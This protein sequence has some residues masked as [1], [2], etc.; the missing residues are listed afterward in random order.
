MSAQFHWDPDTYLGM[1]RQEVPRFDELQAAAIEAIPFA[2]KRVLDLGIG[3][4]ETS[5]RLLEAHPGAEITG[6]DSSP[7]M[8]YR[9]R[10]LGIEARLARMEDPLPDGPWDLVIAVLS[11]H[12]LPAEGKQDLLRRVREQS[13]SLVIGDVVVSDRQVTPIEEGVDF[14][15]SAGNLAEWSG[16]TIAWHADDL[17]V[18]AATYD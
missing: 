15:E 6:L 10:E 17:A 12:H 14:P 18:I 8:V 4:G 2:P 7:E 5:R 13:R 16:A 11:V 3:T 9:A 1:I